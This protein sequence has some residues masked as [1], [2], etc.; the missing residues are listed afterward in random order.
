MPQRIHSLPGSVNPFPTR[1]RLIRLPLLAGFSLVLLAGTSPCFGADWS[2]NATL[3]S[4]Y[5]WRGTTQSSGDP[6]LQAGLKVAAD[7]GFYASV[8]GSNVS[9]G[10]EVG[11][12]TEFD[13]TAGWSGSLGQDWALDANVLH[14]RYPG[15]EVD[16]D[17]TELNVTITYRDNYWLAVGYSPEALGSDDS[18]VY[19][20][21]G[22][23]FPINERFRLEVAVGHYALDAVYDESY[24]H[25]QL[26]A[27]WSPRQAVELRVTAHATDA[28]AK[29]N[30]G[31]SYAGSRVEAA[32]TVSF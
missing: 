1:P 32:A 29:S 11:A 21:V 10:P 31:D 27:I 18:G 13:F 28:N 5:V 6:A 7:S 3:T 12:D 19:T 25:G 15:S 26:S 20:L 24:W 23:R 30:F 17:W 4:D 22:A 2:G 9:F 16:L 8:W 14:Y